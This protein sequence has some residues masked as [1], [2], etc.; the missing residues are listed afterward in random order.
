MLTPCPPLKPLLLASAMSC[1]CTLLALPQAQA[2]STS[3]TQTRPYA[4][5][6]QP[7]ESA[8]VQWSA[9]SGIQLFAD[10][11]L[12]RGK[13]SSAVNGEYTASGALQQLLAGT[14]Q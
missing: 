1:V 13:T 6:A 12:T 7:L 3:Q 2:A 5:A 9:S 14:A 11:A 8:I 4:S 10:G